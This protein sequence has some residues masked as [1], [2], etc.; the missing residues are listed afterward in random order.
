MFN[1]LCEDFGQILG[2]NNLSPIL[3]GFSKDIL[4]RYCRIVGLNEPRQLKG[5]FK[6]PKKQP[7][8][9]EGGNIFRIFASGNLRSSKQGSI[10]SRSLWVAIET[11]VIIYVP[12]ITGSENRDFDI[13]V[14]RICNC[15]KVIH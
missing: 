2:A 11:L 7:S 13:G 6:Q 10:K 4:E 15:R 3:V 12:S 9:E 8:L 14:G 5:L 1:P